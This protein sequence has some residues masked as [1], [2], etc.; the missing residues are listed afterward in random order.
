M[1]ILVVALVFSLSALSAAFSQPLGSTKVISQHGIT[2]TLSHEC[3]YGRF[4]NGDFYVIVSS[5]NVQL[6]SI[7]PSPDGTRNGFM[8]NPIPGQ[9]HSYDSRATN[10]DASAVKTL[11]FQLKANSSIVST[12]SV[13][14]GDV[15][16]DGY[17]HQSWLGYRVSTSH[18]YL[19]DAAILT[20]LAQH[21]PSG[22]F[23]PPYVGDNKPVLNQASINRSKLPM[24][25]PPTGTPTTTM[26]ERALERPWILHGRDWTA[27]A[28]HPV[29]NMPNYHR[30][31]ANVLSEATL[32]LTTK[33]ITDTLLIRYIQLGI[34]YYFMAT[35]GSV[36]DSSFF[37]APVIITGHLLGS[38]EILN[39]FSDSRNKTEPR[40]SMYYFSHAISS[41]I[42]SAVVPEGQTWTGARVF[43]RK[44]TGDS[45]HEHL[46]PSEW[47]AVANGGG[48]KNENYRTSVDCH[49]SIGMTLG[50]QIFGQ[51]AKYGN[52]AILAYADRWMTEDYSSLLTILREYYPTAT[53]G[54]T[55]NAGSTFANAMWSMYRN[56]ANETSTESEGSSP[57]KNALILISQ[58]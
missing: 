4:V 51:S 39:V 27:R 21:P 23:R 20:V 38:N 1:K 57:P 29:N 14:S 19:T 56:Y 25:E 6:T 5:D 49:P 17:L 26:T 10:F 31:I 8:V 33:N 48:M 24:L 28:I 13:T 50:V 58:P 22:S 36:G 35:T 30:E 55:R 54:Y 12:K 16:T 9:K 15:G 37:E 41:K 47:A 53:A 43:F 18:A 44:Q 42:K 34:D 40:G 7:S 32:L 45:E 11:P 52:E 3:E 46:H 2:W